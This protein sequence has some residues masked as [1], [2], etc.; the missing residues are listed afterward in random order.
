M[1]IRKFSFMKA[2]IIYD[3]TQ[4]PIH[5]KAHANFVS[6]DKDPFILKI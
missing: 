5:D 3:P 6:Y 1:E 2:D 4:E